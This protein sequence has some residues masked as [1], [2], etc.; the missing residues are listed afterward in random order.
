MPS[1]AIV[2]RQS[3]LVHQ[4]LFGRKTRV[5]E[6]KDFIKTYGFHPEAFEVFVDIMLGELET[7]KQRTLN[8]TCQVAE[9]TG[10][11]AFFCH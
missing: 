1:T 7:L 4:A 10:W 9:S 3:S 5:D 8:Y 2:V 11:S 6:W